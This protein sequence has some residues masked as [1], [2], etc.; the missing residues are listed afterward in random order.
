MMHASGKMRVLLSSVF[1]PYAQD[2][3]YG[4]RG[5]NPMELWRNQVNRVQGPWSLRMFHRSNGLMMI[6]E[7]VDA[8]RVPVA[9]LARDNAQRA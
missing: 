4:S 2:D 8:T 6:R 5:I 1:G 3:E 7:N 9:D